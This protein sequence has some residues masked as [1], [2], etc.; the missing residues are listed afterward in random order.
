MSKAE[1]ETAAAIRQARP[2]LRL[3]LILALDDWA[4]CV[5]R[6]DDAQAR[7]LSRTRRGAADDDDY[8]KGGVRRRRRGLKRLADEAPGLRLPSVSLIVLERDLYNHG[9]I[10]EAVALL[11]VGRR[12]H[13]TDFWVYDEL[14]SC[15][16]DPNRPNPATLDEAEGSACAAVALR[17]DSAIACCNLGLVM[18]QR[19]DRHRAVDAFQSKPI[20]ARPHTAA[21][22]SATWGELKG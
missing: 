12:Q 11:R 4:G 1:A 17:P 10:P 13:P 2:G 18:D 3:A 8:A 21:V 14:S 22:P 5:R 9:A 16:I 15:L 19:G 6:R 20:R 7:R